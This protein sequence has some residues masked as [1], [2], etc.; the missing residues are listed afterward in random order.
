MH[1]IYLPLVLLWGWLTPRESVD[2]GV[3]VHF[4]RAKDR[5]AEAFVID[6]CCTFKSE[7]E[8]AEPFHRNS[9]K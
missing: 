6:A 3:S 4:S 1:H 9:P 8:T 2:T 7:H 5:I